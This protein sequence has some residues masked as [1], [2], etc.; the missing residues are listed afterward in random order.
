MKSVIADSS[1]AIQDEFVGYIDVTPEKKIIQSIASDIDLKRGIL[2]LVDNAVDEWRA[3]ANPRLNIRLTFDVNKKS[4]VYL[5]NA[6]GILEKNLNM[7]LQPGGTTRTPED[8]S[9]GE[10]GLGSKRAI[11]A[12]SREAEVVSRFESKDTFK[13]VVNDSWASSSS[14]KVP[15]YKTTRIDPSSTQIT[16]NN[17]KFD[18][19][20]KALQ[21]IKQE[22]SD[23]YCYLLSSKFTIHVNNLPI[24]PNRFSH[25]AFPPHRRH[26]RKYKTYISIGERRVTVDV[27][28]GLMLESSQAGNYG[29]DIFCNNRMI[30]KDYKAPEIGFTKGTL[31]SPHS[32]IAWFKGIVQIAGSNMDMPWNSTKSGLD[33]ANPIFQPLKEKVTTL[34]KP[35]VQLSRRLGGNSKRQ[36]AAYPSGQIE[37][38]DL[39]SQEELVLSPKDI[40]DLPPG[41]KSEAEALLA[42]NRRKV[43]DCP[44]TRALIE[45]IYIV[46]LIMRKVKLENKNRFALILLD[47]CLEVAFRDYLFRVTGVKFTRDQRKELSQRKNLISAVK[48]HSSL[49]KAIW[50][51]V[52]YFY[53]LRNSLYHEEASPEIPDSDMARF[54]QVV[55]KALRSLHGLDV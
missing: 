8:H 47:T 54:R 2:E 7:I 49:P 48:A 37:V 53:E 32:A 35:Y 23:T 52:D 19:D 43:R 15:K 17:I 38:V 31:G 13:I 4:L 36:I 30:L 5:D 16:F 21:E 39:T 44:W 33:V 55:S 1:K 29:L 50:D 51:S 14:W 25:W 20:L 11:I 24:E 12:L 18:L 45:N 22:I 27:T 46:D 10:F 28:V 6:G 26:P 34:S 40:P 3:R 9:I 42:R 41:K